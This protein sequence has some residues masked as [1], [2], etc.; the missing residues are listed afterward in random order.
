MIHTAYANSVRKLDELIKELEK[1]YGDGFEFKTILPITSGYIV[2]YSL[3]TGSGK[4]A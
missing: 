3:N 2:Y 1:M 4:D